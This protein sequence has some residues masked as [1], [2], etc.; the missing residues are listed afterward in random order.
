MSH[1]LFQSLSYTLLYSTLLV[2]I[3]IFNFIV[4]YFA[5]NSLIVRPESLELLLLFYIVNF[6]NYYCYIVNCLYL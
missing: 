5:V 6:T 3:V 4:C 1:F 2:F